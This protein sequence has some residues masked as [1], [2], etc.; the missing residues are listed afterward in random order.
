MAR[1]NNDTEVVAWL[2][3]DEGQRWSRYSRNHVSGRGT[4]SEHG[5]F[6]ELKRDDKAE[7]MNTKGALGWLRGQGR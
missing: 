3:S 7:P 6:G 5:V 2:E 1:R 4:D